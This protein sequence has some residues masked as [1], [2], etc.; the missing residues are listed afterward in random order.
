MFHL[1]EGE[2]LYDHEIP[3][4]SL[5][6]GPLYLLAELDDDLVD[7]DALTRQVDS[8][9][10][11]QSYLAGDADSSSFGTVKLPGKARKL[12]AATRVLAFIATH[13]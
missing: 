7:I 3:G 8:F 6:T 9:R 12:A 2:P 10:R 13:Q 11:L 4:I 5:V 1:G